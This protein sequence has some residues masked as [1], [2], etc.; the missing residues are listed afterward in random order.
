MK[1]TAK[2]VLLI[3]TVILL[4]WW[5]FP[6]SSTPNKEVSYVHISNGTNGIG[7]DLC[8]SEEIQSFLN[9]TDDNTY[10]RTFPHLLS[11]G[12]YS[13]VVY[14]YDENMNVIESFILQDGRRGQVDFANVFFFENNEIRNY[15]EFLTKKS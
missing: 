14:F 2:I 7:C 15:L 12:G 4:G 10:I 1:K 6:R 8:S 11:S 5:F 3:L 13:F 9:V